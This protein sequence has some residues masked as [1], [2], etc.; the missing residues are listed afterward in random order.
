MGDLSEHEKL[1]EQYLLENNREAAVQ[2]LVELIVKKTGEK[3]FGEAEFLRD[4]LFEVDAMALSEIVKTGEVI[5]I[6]KRNAIDQEHLTT[7]SEFYRNLTTEETNALYYRMRMAEYP[8]NHM[9][10]KQGEMRS[11]LYFI[12]EGRLKMFYRQADKAI[13]LKILEPG[14]IFGE[15]TFFFSDGFCTTSVITDSQVKL[16]ELLK[17][18]L[19]NLSAKFPGLDSKVNDYCLS[20]ISVADL[21]KA[22]KLER[23]VDKRLNLQGK[24]LV[25]TLN[26]KDQP[27]SKPFRGELID[28]SSSGLAFIMKTTQKASGMLLGRKLN[29]KL[30]FDEL[31]SDLEIIRV[32]SV[33]AVNS[34]PFHEFVVHAEFNTNLETYVMDDLEDLL[35][36]EAV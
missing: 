35:N 15:D 33:V 27:E 2:L 30:T 34:E 17:D 6:G 8:A 16:Y 19:A 26:H 5:E 20:R 23:R 13:L 1:I 14:E 12:D 10:F 3:K 18:D 11:R 9:I 7:W 21:L 4:K 29:L 22:K 36:F 24:V 28:I 32:G 25:Q 31:A